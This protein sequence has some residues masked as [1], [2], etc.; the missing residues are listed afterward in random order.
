MQKNLYNR[1]RFFKT[2]L[3]ILSWLKNLKRNGAPEL[4][5]NYVSKK[6]YVFNNCV[7]KKIT[8]AILSL[9]PPKKKLL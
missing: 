8:V 4:K 1:L 9:P 2:I 7:L 3:Y 6:K 5:K